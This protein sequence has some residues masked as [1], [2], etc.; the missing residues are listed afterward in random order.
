MTFIGT[1]RWAEEDSHSKGGTHTKAGW[2]EKPCPPLT[3]W[4]RRKL[5]ELRMHPWAALQQGEPFMTQ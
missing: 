5:R 4:R 3:L 2:E 1:E